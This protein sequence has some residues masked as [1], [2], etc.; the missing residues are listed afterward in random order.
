MKIPIGIRKL[1]AAVVAIV[2]LFAAYFA[3][4]RPW[5]LHWG[6]SAYEARAVLPGDERVPHATS[7]STR[8]VTIAVPPARVWPW[9]AQ[10]GQDRGGFYSYDVLENA[11]GSQ[12][13]RA[14][15][16]LRNRQEWKPGDK[17]WLYPPHKAHGAGSAPL[18]RY[19]PGRALVF[20]TRPLGSAPGAREAG[21]WTLV[22]QPLGRDSS[23]L[24]ARGI[25]SQ[26]LSPGMATF[27]TLL[28]EPT[29]FV[30]E[31]RML[32]NIKALAE[33]RTTS[34]WSELAEVCMWT[35]AVFLMLFALVEVWRRQ[36]W[37][38]PLL[39]AA[40][41]A[42]V[43]ALLTFTQ[44]PWLVG[45]MFVG[46]LVLTL[47]WTETGPPRLPHIHRRTEESAVI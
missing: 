5:M 20:G 44:P 29:H 7:A 41:A 42:V 1:L 43:F 40:G 19:E 25:S 34:A 24:I 26:R 33:G 22:L 28:F 23:R 31:R 13:P 39:V 21:V 45:A 12:M 27:N 11:V 6:A 9:L 10:L 37:I 4:A 3:F 30:M 15:T 38:A 35:L 32:L 46:A 16:I 18:V 47:W 36:R 8:A 17:L 2:A 14:T